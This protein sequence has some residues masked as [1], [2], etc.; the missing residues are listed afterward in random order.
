MIEQSGIG[1]A[2]AAIWR[3]C[4]PGFAERRPAASRRIGVGVA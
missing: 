2:P 3:R 1:M 4:H